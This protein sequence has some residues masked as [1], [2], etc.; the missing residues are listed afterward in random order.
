MDNELLQQARIAAARLELG[1]SD[2]ITL[3]WA[4]QD[5]RA[6]RSRYVVNGIRSAFAAM[7]RACAGALARARS[8]A[9][10]H[11]RIAE[12]KRHAMR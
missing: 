10:L 4:E 11:V 7:L 8:A 12:H 2:P 3:A 9:R 6:L 5:F 1:K